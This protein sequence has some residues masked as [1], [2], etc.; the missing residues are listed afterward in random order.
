MKWALGR[1]GLL[2][3]LATACNGCTANLMDP[4]SWD[5]FV[6]RPWAPPTET[7]LDIGLPFE[8]LRLPVGGGRTIAAWYIPAQSD[9]PRATYIFHTGAEGNI[10]RFLPEIAWV[11]GTD[12]NLLIYDWQGFGASDG[13]ADFRNFEVDTNAAIDYLRQRPEPSARR[14]I[15]VGISLGSLPA[16]AVAAENP[17]ITIGMILYG[18]FFPEDLPRLLIE[19]HSNP[20]FA[21]VGDVVGGGWRLILPAF[22]Q[23]INYIGR[24]Q[25]PILVIT[26]TDDERVPSGTQHRLYDLLPEPKEQ[27]FSTGSHVTTPE[28][29]A[30]L[31]VKIL[32]WSNALLEQLEVPAEE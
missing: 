8:D 29:D 14:I 2:V 28:L 5:R 17:D 18:P 25:V 9:T 3:C 27:Y 23:P 15:H 13:I 22:M 24:L 6:L 20:A 30:G 12:F 19:R 10:A 31:P 32:S 26:P 21:V 16:I 1:G 4:W 7:P 11:A